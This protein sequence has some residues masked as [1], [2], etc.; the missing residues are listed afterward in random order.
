MT[1]SL[2]ILVRG[3]YRKLISIIRWRVDHTHSIM[4]HVIWLTVR[5]L[6]HLRNFGRRESLMISWYQNLTRSW[7]LARHT[8][9]TY[10]PAIVSCLSSGLTF[11]ECLL[12]LILLIGLLAIVD[13]MDMWCCWAMVDTLITSK[14][15]HLTWVWLSSRSRGTLVLTLQT[16]CILVSFYH[17]SWAMSQTA[18]HSWILWNDWILD[19]LCTDTIYVR[20]L[21]VGRNSFGSVWWELY[22][23][24]AH[25]RSTKPVDLFPWL[26]RELCLIAALNFFCWSNCLFH[27][28]TLFFVFLSILNLAYHFL[29][30]ALNPG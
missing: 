8:Y 30:E 10:T 20:W 22:R 27:D 21:E 15:T 13:L 3:W 24:F 4:L 18:Y 23:S 1:I 6:K 28:F 19:S 12:H 5:I 14:I 25:L 7:T 11:N 2:S 16:F 9:V 29:V 17:F 26:L